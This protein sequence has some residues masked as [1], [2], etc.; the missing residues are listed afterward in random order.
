M[1]KDAYHADDQDVP[2]PS[3]ADTTPLAVSRHTGD[4]SKSCCRSCESGLRTSIALL[5]APLS[6]ELRCT[7]LRV[8]TVW[9]L[10]SFSYSGFTLWLPEMLKSKG[11]RSSDTYTLYGI[12][13]LAEIPSLCIATALVHAGL[14]KRFLLAG[15]GAGCGIAMVACAVAGDKAMLDTAL[16]ASY[17]F[18]VSAWASLYVITPEAYP[19]T[20]RST[21]SGLARFCSCLGS[22]SS[23]PVGAALLE[24]GVWALLCTCGACILLLAAVAPCLPASP[25][26]PPRAAPAPL[27]ALGAPPEAATVSALGRRVEEDGDP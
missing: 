1:T 17:F 12:M 23:A 22:M 5:L 9:F 13:V 26:L 4:D 15:C 16:A 14:Q 25:P 3:P 19:A 7:T 2:E 24:A 6:R 21:A 10:M 20:C 8:G 27:L 18:V 11:I